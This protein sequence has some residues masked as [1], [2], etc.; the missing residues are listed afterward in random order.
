MKPQQVPVRL[1]TVLG[2]ISCVL[3]GPAAG[4]VWTTEVVDSQGGEFAS[5]AL[6][7]A[8]NPHVSYQ[9]AQ[10]DHYL[11]YAAFD[12][13]SWSTEAI[14]PGGVRTSLAIDPNGVEHISHSTDPLAP[15][16]TTVLRYVT[17][18]AGSWQGEDVGSGGSTSIALNTSGYPRI[19]HGYTEVG[20]NYSTWDGNA[21]SCETVDADGTDNISL[22]LTDDGRAC[23]AYNIHESSNPG[24]ATWVGAVTGWSLTTVDMPGG[25]PSLALDSLGHPHIAYQGSGYDLIY[26]WWDGSNWQ[27]TTVSDVGVTGTHPSLALDESDNP[28]I[29]YWHDPGDGP[30]TLAYAFFD[31]SAWAYEPVALQ[32]GPSQWDISLALGADG[33]LH[34]AYGESGQLKYARG[35]PEP[36]TLALLA[37][38]GLGLVA[39]RKR[40]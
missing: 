39:A 40:R 2:V 5:L 9:S 18:A 28:H 17:R 8:G 10:G 16:F 33:V 36:T 4:M 37:V 38:G 35:V 26:T 21:W 30:G 29:A 34:I 25:N 32:D 3:C 13:T 20:L 15:P 7:P 23:I 22:A 1:I 12:G 19:A 14:E 24:Y 31:G 11:R 6:D 27:F